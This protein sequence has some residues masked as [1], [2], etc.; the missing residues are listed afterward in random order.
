MDRDRIPYFMEMIFI[1]IPY[2]KIMNV[3]MLHAFMEYG[4]EKNFFWS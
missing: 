2:C 1:S 4:N 3:R